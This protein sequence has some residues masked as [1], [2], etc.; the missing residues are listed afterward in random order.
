MNAADRRQ[1]LD[2]EILAEVID[3]VPTSIFWKDRDGVFLGCNRLLA[4]RL[5][6]D[7]PD[8][9][10]GKTDA[11]LFPPEQAAFFRACDVQVMADDAP[12]RNI[13]EPQRR[14]DGTTAW[15]LTSRVPLHD[16]ADRVVGILGAFTDITERKRTEAA[17]HRLEA[18]L[19]HAGKLDALGQLAGG[20]AHDFNNVLNAVL[21]YAELI[22]DR[23]DDA[24]RCER[25]GKAIL[26]AGDQAVKLT[27]QLLAFSRRHAERRAPVDLG[28]LVR[29]QLE[30]LGGALGEGIAL[31]L[32][33]PD[34][35]VVVEGDR[36]QLEQVVLNLVLNARDAMPDGGPLDVALRAVEGDAELV[37][38]DAGAGIAPEHRDRV[39]EP[40][41]TTRRSG[42]GTGLGLATVHGV[43]TSHGGDVS[44]ESEPG[45]GTTF[46]IR[47]P[48][49]DAPAEPTSPSGRLLRPTRRGRGER[50][51]VV[52]DEPAVAEVVR[53]HLED[54][55]YRTL[56]A[57]DGVEALALLDEVRAAGAAGAVDLVLTDVVMPRL[58]GLELVERLEE[59]GDPPPVVFMSGYLDDE[60][61][62]ELLARAGPRFLAK[63]FG[64]D[65][66]AR[67]IAAGLAL[68]DDGDAAPDA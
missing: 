32:D 20:I 25:A 37:V 65:D 10:V 47:L 53:E 17:K 8:E 59:R 30:T 54:L 43:V 5:G 34:A 7:D 68:S 18:D 9:I 12:M 26:K 14:P 36:N 23:P 40:F 24:A 63:P 52:E 31:S 46:R 45:Q 4:E 2:S 41:F 61:A 38:R 6:L 50:V 33:L 28:D 49:S 42:Q 27:R 56:A 48:R 58:G 62:R 13:E 67:A 44:F 57:G 15:I 19:R 16:A 29:E 11:D 60:R 3:G 22:A 64:R 66:L 35:P 21:G 51:L 39:F 1:P 55:G